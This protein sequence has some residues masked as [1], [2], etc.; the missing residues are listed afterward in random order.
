MTRVANEAATPHPPSLRLKGIDHLEFYVGNA[1]QAA[2]FYCTTFGFTAVAYA[3]LETGVRDRVSFVLRQRDIRFVLTSALDPDSPIARHVHWHGDGIKD[4]AFTVDDAEQTFHEAVR[5]GARAVLEPTRIETDHGQVTR[6]TIAACNDT[7]HSLIQ[8]RGYEASFLPSYQPIDGPPPAFSS[9]LVALDHIAIGLEPGGLDQWIEFYEQVLGFHRSHQEDVLTE[10]S[11]MNSKVVQNDTGR[12]KFPMMEPAPGR[13][14]SQIEEYL[15]FHKGAGV[16]HVALLSSNILDSMAT[17]KA[18]HIDF[19]PTPKTYYDLLTDRIGAIDEDVDALR[20]LGILA[21]RDE[22]GYL[23]QTFTKPLQS[24]PT[25]F[26]EVIQRKGAVGF[27]SGNIK[28]LFE[29]IER[30]QAARGN[31]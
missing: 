2:H 11:A 22:S 21:D 5:R 25:V 9:K 14:K 17:L 15:N 8:R 24:R 27:G 31:L 4:I 29:A 19:L 23:M 6:A 10:Y 13:R 18:N 12:V 7:V 1:Y 16:Q 26:M 28:A 3:G 20:D 30:Q